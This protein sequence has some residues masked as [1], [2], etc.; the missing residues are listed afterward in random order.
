MK[1][2]ITLL[3]VGA[4]AFS[5]GTPDTQSP[6][7]DTT[8]ISKDSSVAINDRADIH[9]SCCFQTEKD[10]L[11]FF[12]DTIGGFIGMDG[13]TAEMKCITDTMAHSTSMKSYVNAKGHV[14]TVT[15]TDYCATPDILR[16]DYHIKFESYTGLERQG[17][18]NEF[19]VAGYYHGFSHFDSDIRLAALVV[20]VDNRFEVEIIDQVCDNT[21]NVLM[22]Y[23]A[24][25]LKE[26][27]EFGN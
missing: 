1:I 14:V 23:E 12:P 6:D 9:Q 27:S 5:C 11:P 26:L 18:F 7:A 15:I 3:L 16:T 25:P 21:K 10:F 19:E 13:R 17:E 20:V 2:S 22:I 8:R 24:L 4:L